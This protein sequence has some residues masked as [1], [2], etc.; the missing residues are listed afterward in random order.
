MGQS[1]KPFKNP[2]KNLL[3]LQ[4]STEEPAA[5][6][7]TKRGRRATPSTSIRHHARRPIWTTASPSRDGR[8]WPPYGDGHC[9]SHAKRGPMAGETSASQWGAL[10]LGP[11]NGGLQVGQ[12]TPSGA[13]KTGGDHSSS[14]GRLKQRWTMPRAAVTSST[15]AWFAD[16]RGSEI[17]AKRHSPCMVRRT[18]S[19]SVSCMLTRLCSRSRSVHSRYFLI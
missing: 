15:I 13:K 2:L 10:A 8:P 18:C 11:P 17:R 14:G 3:D 7:K 16:M 5:E 19:L 6:C 9:R 4:C 1:R 12:E